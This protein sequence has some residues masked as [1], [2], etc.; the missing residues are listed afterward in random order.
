MKIGFLGTWTVLFML[1]SNAALAV[2]A[3][4]ATQQLGTSLD[5]VQAHFGVLV[6][7]LWS[8]LGLIGD[9][10]KDSASMLIAALCEPSQTFSNLEQRPFGFQAVTK[11]ISSSL[12][13]VGLSTGRSDLNQLFVQMIDPDRLVTSIDHLLLVAAT[14]PL[15]DP[16]SPIGQQELLSLL[17]IEKGAQYANNVQNVFIQSSILLNIAIAQ[18]S[19]LSG[20]ILLPQL[21]DFVQRGG[22][23]EK[24]LLALSQNSILTENLML[25]IV[26]SSLMTSRRLRERNVL[27]ESLPATATTARCVQYF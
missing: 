7:M 2:N 16:R 4:A 17:D 10:K 1:F 6:N 5:R 22:S 20:D 12:S 8:S 3:D 15:L 19:L 13:K 18:Q 27:G 9:W 21:R 26:R 25:Y 14:W 23:D 11:E 24:I